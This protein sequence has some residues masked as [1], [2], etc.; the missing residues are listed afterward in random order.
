MGLHKTIELSFL[1]VGHTKLAPDG[2]FGLLKKKFRRTKVSCLEDIRRVVEESADVNHAQL[3]GTQSGESVVPTY[4]WT[5]LLSPRMKKISGI[6]RLHHIT[7]TADQKDGVKVT[8]KQYSD[9]NPKAVPLLRDKTWRPS[10][11][12]LPPVISPAGLDA[13]RQWYLHNEIREYCTEETKDLVCP[14]P[15]VPR[16]SARSIDEDLEEEDDQDEEVMPAPA[17]LRCC[18]KCHQP[19]HNRRT[20]TN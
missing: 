19:G 18:G 20:C 13:A 16:P 12:D 6:K 15:V 2:C 1:I 5:S 8:V 17:Q 3:V 9:N 7:I 4:N 11:N 14:L 10:P